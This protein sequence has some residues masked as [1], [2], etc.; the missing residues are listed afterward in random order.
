MRAASFVTDESNLMKSIKKILFGLLLAGGA[1]TSAF[2]TPF[3][4]YQDTVFVPADDSG[5]GLQQTWWFSA[6]QDGVLA[7][8][9]FAYQFLFNTPP[10]A[11]T[12]WF[13][14]T[15]DDT[16]DVSF[17][18]AGLFAFDA[19]AQ[20]VPDFLDAFSP[21]AL[22]GQGWLDSG[23]YDLYLTGTFLAD[24]AYFA[25]S[26]IDDVDAPVPEP[27]TLGLIAA[28][29]AALGSM[30]RRAARPRFSESH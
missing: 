3:Y 15:V 29:L 8:Q 10:S 19:S 6:G 7:G 16:H 1:V 5:P 2:A 28:G 13:G 18:F 20:P 30:R 26:A 9:T 14:L 25:G 24:G 4:D 17:D 12:T 23:V 11:P 27:A 21:T 22:H